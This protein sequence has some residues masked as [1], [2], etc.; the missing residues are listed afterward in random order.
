MT[1]PDSLTLKKAMKIAAKIERLQQKLHELL[2]ATLKL[3]P[4]TETMKSQLLEV[5]KTPRRRGRPPGSGKKL[6]LDGTRSPSKLAGRPRPASPSGPL[7]PAVVKVLERYGRPMKVNEILI[8]LE[9]D[10]YIWTAKNPRQTLYVRIGKLAG[11]RKS[12][13]GLYLAEGVAS[14][15]VVPEAVTPVA[16]SHADS[17]FGSE[18]VSEVHS[19]PIA[20]SEPASF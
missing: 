5:A 20:P 3:P 12:E 11:V 4:A 2:G 13:E 14:T 16:A 18:V 7:A 9:H 10:N 17:S 6:A 1:I 8:G 19:S 15:G